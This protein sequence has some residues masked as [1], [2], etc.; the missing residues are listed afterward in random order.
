MPISWERVKNFVAKAFLA[1]LII[2][3]LGSWFGF[4]KQPPGVHEGQA[5]GLG[6]HW[7]YVGNPEDPDLSCEPDD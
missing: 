2:Y 3:A 1:C 5:C 6:H 4:I 7:K